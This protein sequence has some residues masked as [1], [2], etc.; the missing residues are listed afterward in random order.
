LGKIVPAV[1]TK[2][3]LTPDEWRGRFKVVYQ[4]DQCFPGAFF[5]LL[6]SAD[7]LFG[8]KVTSGLSM[9]DLNKKLGYR[10][11]AA[12]PAEALEKRAIKRWLGVFGLDVQWERESPKSF[13]NLEASTKRDDL[14]FS[15][16]EVDLHLVTD[17]DSKAKIKGPDFS[18]DHAIVVLKIAN[19]Q[20]EFF[21]PTFNPAL[22]S[23]A[24]TRQAL[25]TPQ[26]VKRWSRCMDPYYRV[27]VTRAIPLPV[28]RMPREGLRGVPP[29]SRWRQKGR[30]VQP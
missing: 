6:T 5:A 22:P 28:R 3:A 9:G 25:S 12:T 17:Y 2:S 13:D 15:L 1:A 20:V 26:F 30:G 10:K 14:S 11:G 4:E 23:N 16:T 21:D 7:L 18:T 29:L 24:G 8:T 19:G 27:W